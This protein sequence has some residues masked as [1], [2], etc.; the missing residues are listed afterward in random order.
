MTPPSAAWAGTPTASTTAGTRRWSRPD[1]HTATSVAIATAAMRKVTIRLPNSMAVWIV[2]APCGRND[3]SVQRGHVGQPRPEP[4]S[5]TTPPVTTIA[6]LTTS[7]ATRR[8][9]ATPPTYAGAGALSGE[10]TS[11]PTGTSWPSA[12]SPTTVH[13][14]STSDWSS[15]KVPCTRLSRMPLPSAPDGR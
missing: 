12:R 15:G 13:T 7:E 10:V 9:A 14:S 2:I 11:T 8:A 6:T 1:R 3:S 4:V 5:R